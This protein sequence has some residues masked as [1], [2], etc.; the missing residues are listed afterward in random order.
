[1]QRKLDMCARLAESLSVEGERLTF[2]AG[3]IAAMHGHVGSMAPGGPSWDRYEEADVTAEAGFLF[4]QMVSWSKVRGVVTL[5]LVYDVSHGL[6][7][8]ALIV[9]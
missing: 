3:R 7:T 1:M 2:E 9:T 6:I 5:R 4:R 8:A